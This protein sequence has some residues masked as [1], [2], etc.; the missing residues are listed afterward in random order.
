MTFL[1]RI[2]E[3]IRDLLLQVP[4]TGVRLL[5]VGS[6]IAVLLWVLTMPKECT[7]PEGGARRWDENLKWSAGLAL[8][9]QILVYSLL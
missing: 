4:L 6:L 2:G 3:A 8:G 9:I 7:E 5:F 1:H